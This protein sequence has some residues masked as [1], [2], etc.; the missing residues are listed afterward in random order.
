FMFRTLFLQLSQPTLKGYP[1]NVCTRHIHSFEL[2]T[3]VRNQCDSFHDPFRR[4]AERYLIRVFASGSRHNSYNT[5]IITHVNMKS[6]SALPEA[7][8][9]PR[10]S[11]SA[12]CAAQFT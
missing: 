6:R 8:R 12:S 11:R 7:H 2:T 4:D 5:T 9:A 3:D 10:A 1:K